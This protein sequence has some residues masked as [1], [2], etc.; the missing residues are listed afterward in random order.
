VSS[1][2]GAA[3]DGEA[4]HERFLR[5]VPERA[6]LG[7][8]VD[9]LEPGAT[10]VSVRR[11]KGGLEAS[12]HRVDLR[13]RSG[14]RRPIVVRRFNRDWRWFSPERLPA[15]VATLQSLAP[16]PVPA[17]ECLL[18]D[19]N[20]EWLDTPTM[21]VS[22]L[23]GGPAPPD[24]WAEWSGDLVDAMIELHAVTPV[25]EAEPWLT[26]WQRGEDLRSLADDP[27]YE[28]VWPVVLALR[29]E[30]AASGGDALVHH[31]LHPGNTLWRRGRLS[32]VVDWP[33]AGRGF[34]AYDRAYLRLDVSLC[35]GLAAGDAF[36]AT[37][38]SRGLA[39]DHPAWDLVVGVRALPPDPWIGVYNELGVTL[40]LEE[41]RARLEEWFDRALA[42]LV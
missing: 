9:H 40:S 34:A 33:M 3:P 37:M 6:K 4:A 12:T 23:P 19:E 1:S 38:R 16:T 15:E 20:G 21:V 25:V 18:L 36:A 39:E 35:Q 13:T 17:P 22:C 10:V 32:G 30:L 2:A 24:R 27:T 8:L 5:S 7:R 42:H 31:D 14:G 29:D 26:A 28:R 41:G 11:L